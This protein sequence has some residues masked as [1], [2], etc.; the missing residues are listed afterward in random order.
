MGRKRVI[1]KKS[2]SPEISG[3]IP[4]ISGIGTLGDIRQEHLWK[5]FDRKIVP[6][7]WLEVEKKTQLSV[8]TNITALVI[9]TGKQATRAHTTQHALL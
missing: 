6:Y 7:Q 4:E 5:G 3:I 2:R 9:Q 1:V 8:M